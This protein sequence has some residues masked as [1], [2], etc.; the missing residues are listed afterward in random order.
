[1]DRFECHFE[2]GKSTYFSQK[3]SLDNFCIYKPFSAFSSWLPESPLPVIMQWSVLLPIQQ[4]VQF[5]HNDIWHLKNPA[6]THMII[7]PLATPCTA[8]SP[9]QEEMT[10]KNM[11]VNKTLWN[12]C[13]ETWNKRPGQFQAGKSHHFWLPENI[14]LESQYI[15]FATVICSAFARG[16]KLFSNGLSLLFVAQVVVFEARDFFYLFPHRKQ[17]PTVEHTRFIRLPQQLFRSFVLESDRFSDANVDHTDLHQPQ[18]FFT[19]TCRPVFTQLSNKRHSILSTFSGHHKHTN[20]GHQKYD[21]MI[22]LKSHLKFP[23]KI[24]SKKN[25]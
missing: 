15:S 5:F 13:T 12:N 16:Q 17:P 18:F 3:L 20:S 7:S 25:T 10:D 21:E 4:T 19:N 8:E 1:M 24:T 9:A 6:K 11:D 2:S 22:P 23:T 14:N